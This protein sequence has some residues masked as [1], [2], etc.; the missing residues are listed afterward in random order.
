MQSIKNIDSS[1][2]SNANRVQQQAEF[3]FMMGG[4]P[5]KGQTLYQD[6]NDT[7]KKLLPAEFNKRGSLSQ[8]S[9]KDPK[10]HSSNTNK[11]LS[12]QSFQSVDQKMMLPKI[13]SQSSDGNKPVEPTN[14]ALISYRNPT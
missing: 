2:G 7:V 1:R 5:S 8:V 10:T 6:G 4:A 12:N 13:V 14:I 3:S 11:V 9:N